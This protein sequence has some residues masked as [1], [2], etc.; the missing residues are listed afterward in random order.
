MMVSSARRTLP[1]TATESM[2]IGPLD[3]SCC[4]R[5]AV[6]EISTAKRTAHSGNI[7][8][9]LNIEWDKSL[10]PRLKSY[11]VKLLPD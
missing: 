3:T 11:S 9:D 5:T 10:A 1:F 4:A 6:G 2:R 7:F 8:T